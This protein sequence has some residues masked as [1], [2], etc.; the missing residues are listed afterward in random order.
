M[1]YQPYTLITGAS[2]VLGKALA[3]ECAKRQMCLVLVSLP[4]ESL[5]TLATFIQKNYDVDVLYYEY[6]LTHVQSCKQLFEALK[7]KT[8]VELIGI[9]GDRLI[10]LGLHP[11]KTAREMAVV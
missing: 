11:V 2:E 5:Q 9:G 1:K 4:N 7:E 10:A 8:N 3:F 6:D